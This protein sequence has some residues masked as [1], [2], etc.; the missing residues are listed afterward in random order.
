MTQRVPTL[1]HGGFALSE[2]TAITGYLDETFPETPIYSR[3]RNHR[4]RARQLQACHH[5][6]SRLALIKRSEP[7]PE[8]RADNTPI[9][10]T[11]A[12]GFG[13]GCDDPFEG[14][15]GPASAA[16]LRRACRSP[17]L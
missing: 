1:V 10:R 11:V 2:S 13:H 3:D 7:R 15:D 16:L 9:S 8:P 5:I 17:A 6:E 4:A 14:N 12:R